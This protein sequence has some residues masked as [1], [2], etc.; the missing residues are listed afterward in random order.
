MRRLTSLTLIILLLFFAVPQPLVSANGWVLSERG[1]YGDVYYNPSTRRHKT[2]IHTIPQNYLREGEYTPIDLTIYEVDYAD[3]KYA[4][5]NNSFNAFFPEFFIWQ[6]IDFSINGYSFTWLLE[7]ASYNASEDYLGV[8]NE[9]APTL[10]SHYNITYNDAFDGLDIDVTYEL[11]TFGLKEWIILNELPRAP[12]EWLGNPTLD[13]GEIISFEGLTIYVNDTEAPTSFTTS[14]EIEFR[15][16]THT[17]FKLPIPY[18][19]DH[20]GN[21]TN[22]FFQ[23]QKKGNKVWM[24]IRTPYHWISDP[25][26][27]LP[28]K[29]D[30][31][32]ESLDAE[33][34]NV[35][36]LRTGSYYVWGNTQTT[37]RCGNWDL[38]GTD[39]TYRGGIDWNTSVIPDTAT[40]EEVNITLYTHSVIGSPDSLDLDEMTGG[41]ATDGAAKNYLDPPTDKAGFYSDADGETYLS[42][43]SNFVSTGEHT[44][45]LLSAAETDLQNQ[46]NED[47]FTTGTTI[48]TETSGDDYITYR[49]THYD[50]NDPQITV[51]FSLGV[52][53]IADLDTTATFAVEIILNHNMFVDLSESIAVAVEVLLTRNIIVDLTAS[54]AAT[55][56]ILIRWDAILDLSQEIT[57]D[58]NLDYQRLIPDTKLYMFTALAIVG[59]AILII[60][61]DDRKKRK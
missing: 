10:G 42:Q 41:D 25:E 18:A 28:I 33:Y 1:L 14:G 23:V 21:T 44:A 31:S 50:G 22:C 52:A 37:Q 53:Y 13:F 51:T 46:L 47:W 29:I 24:Y 49:G 39:Y 48:H 8:P 32:P 36:Y 58:L 5:L 57:I 59:A 30:A 38:A 60:F 45:T 26:R 55:L 40:I 35:V 34:N 9:A 6:P 16:A 27:V 12:A 61:Y 11:K 7:E 43:D 15:N 54:I 20:S 4:M 2:T 56:E 19:V 17:V 3:Y